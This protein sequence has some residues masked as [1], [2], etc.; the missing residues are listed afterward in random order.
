MIPVVHED[1]E[2]LAVDKPEGVPCQPVDM[3][4][5]DDLPWRLQR[6]RGLDYLGVH[7]RLDRDTSGVVVYAKRREAN[8]GLAAQMEG[9]RVEKRYVAIVTGWRGGPRRLEHALS[10]DGQGDAVV[11][12]PGDRRAKRAVT[13]VERVE[14]VGERARLEIRIETGRTHQI[15]AQLAAEGA[16]VCG[17]RRYGGE[18]APRMMLHAYRLGLRHPTTDV[19]LAIEAP[20]PPLFEAWLTGAYDPFAPGEL[21]A[22][23][24]RAAERRYGLAQRDDLDAWRL[25]DADGDGVPGVAIDRYRDWLVVSLYDEGLPHERAVV[26]AA[27][28]LPG[29]RGV[30]VKRRPRQANVIVQ[31]GDEHAPRE[32]VRGE[33]APSPLEIVE[34]GVP[35]LVRLDEGLSTGLFL[36]QRSNRA[37]VR[38][39]AAGRRVLNLFAYTCGFSVAAGVGGARETV[40]V[41]ASA[42]ALAWGRANLARSGLAAERHRVERADCF[43]ALRDLARRGERF[44]LVIL[45]P[46]TY[47]T[48]RAT[49][50][51][52]GKAWRGLARLALDVLAPEGRLLACSNDRRMSEADFRRHLHA[53]A[54]DAGVTLAQLKDLGPPPDFRSETAPK[55]LLATRG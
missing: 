31:A 25:L 39:L 18:R 53:A 36:D 29:V 27:A 19:P 45:D 28:G 46:P 50:W 7:Q 1:D 22:A 8:R 11:A 40:S 20:P 35:Y 12:G 6:E 51:S 21:A 33:P 24:A 16:P 9:R 55:S 13:H 15:R 37:R 47:S 41:D 38:E 23:L 5:R 30:Y 10:R 44:D 2:L 49:R 17:D 42:P 34:L 32:P 14:R 54:R 3:D 43:E 48:T 26:D 4:H 52:G